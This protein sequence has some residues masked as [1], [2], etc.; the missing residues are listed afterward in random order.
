MII[1]T[2]L[3]FKEQQESKEAFEKKLRKPLQGTLAQSFTSTHFSLVLHF[4]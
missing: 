2:K 4:I 1:T 3:S